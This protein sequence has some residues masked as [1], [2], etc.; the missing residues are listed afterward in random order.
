VRPLLAATAACAGGGVSAVE[1]VGLGRR[2]REAAGVTFT[3]Q[4]LGHRDDADDT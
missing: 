2:A 1:V 3:F 4:K